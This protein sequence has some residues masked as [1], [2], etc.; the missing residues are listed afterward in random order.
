MSLGSLGFTAAC[1][2]RLSWGQSSYLMMV[3][4]KWEPRAGPDC[5]DAHF[6]EPRCRL[7]PSCRDFQL[8]CMFQPLHPGTKCDAHPWTVTDSAS[9]PHRV[10]ALARHHLSS[11]G[12]VLN[13]YCS[14]LLSC[15]RAARCRVCRSRRAAP[16]CSC[17]RW[18]SCH[19]STTHPHRLA[20]PRTCQAARCTLWR[21]GGH[22]LL[23]S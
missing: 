7:S 10:V 1:R 23:T 2:P 19:G 21:S 11:C 9:R 20:P 8:H 22:R 6:L 13:A 15:C 4:A 14:S 16:T 3:I 5:F 12:F 17:P 18:G